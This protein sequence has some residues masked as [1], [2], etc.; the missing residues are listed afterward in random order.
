MYAY[1]V[2]TFFKKRVFYLRLFDVIAY[3]RL[4]PQPKR[5]LYVTEPAL[6][7]SV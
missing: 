1:L 3:G 6:V 2:Y 5:R 4:R 7:T